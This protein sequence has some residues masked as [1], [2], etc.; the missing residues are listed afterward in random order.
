MNTTTTKPLTIEDARILQARKLAP[1]GEDA[2][3]AEIMRELARERSL[4]FYTKIRAATVGLD[5][6][7]WADI[8]DADNGGRTS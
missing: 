7:D 8:T 4:G 5:F 2:R 3:D 1:I 6:E